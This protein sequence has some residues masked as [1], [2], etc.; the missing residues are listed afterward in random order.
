MNLG[1]CRSRPGA[2]TPGVDH[3]TLPGRLRVGYKGAVG[4]HDE[5]GHWTTVHS[6]QLQDCRVFTVHR[7]LWRSP[8]GE[9]HPFFRIDAPDWVNVVPITEDG[10][11]VFIRQFR[12]GAGKI[13]LEI[14]G[15]MVDPGESPATA[16]ARELL[17]ET[18]YRGDAVESLGVVNPNPALFT[19]RCHTFVARNATQVANITNTGRE[20]TEVELIP[21]DEVPERLLAGDIEHALVVAALY[22]WS[23]RG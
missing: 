18:G 13:T 7:D 4:H 22:W 21:A 19:N 6:E 14:P 15:G 10:R 9:E 8:E 1:G 3:S 17:E 23:L 5:V 12:H 2:R 16:A 11:V 20:R